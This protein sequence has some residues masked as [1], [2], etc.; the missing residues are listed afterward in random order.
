MEHK[1]SHI[2][3]YAFL[4]YWLCSR[5][6][7]SQW[8]CKFKD[9]ITSRVHI[10]YSDA[11]CFQIVLTLE[12]FRPITLVPLY[13]IHWG[14]WRDPCL[15]FVHPQNNSWQKHWY[16]ILL[17]HR[18]WVCF[19]RWILKVIKNLFFIVILVIKEKDLDNYSAI[20]LNEGKV[21][22]YILSP[23]NLI[24]HIKLT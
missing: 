2:Q 9:S 6:V 23:A 21:L 14:P 3:I 17:T 24:Y 7:H 22:D 12:V 4:K 1:Y 19:L 11:N 20:F 15:T 5:Q 10:F 18:L 8:G 16:V 13:G